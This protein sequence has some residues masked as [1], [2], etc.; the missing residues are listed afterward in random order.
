M[1]IS[2]KGAMLLMALCAFLW[3]TGGLLIKLLPWHPAV[4]SGLRSAIAAL[5][6]LIY[7]KASR[8]RLSFSWKGLGAGV[9]LGAT[10]LLFVWANK[11]TTSANAIVLQ[12]TNPVH[13]VLLSA[14]FLG[15][16]YSRRE[17]LAVAAA[18][19]GVAL[20]FFDQLTPGGLLGNF[21]ALGSGLTMGAMFLFSSRLPDDQQAITS[22][23][24]GHGLAAA[25][26]LLFLPG[27]PVELTPVTVGAIL[28]LGVFQLGVPYIL[29]ALAV[30]RCSPLS[31]S[32]LSMLEPLLNPV[33]VFL[34]MGEKPGFFALAGGIIALTGLLYL[35]LKSPGAH[36][37]G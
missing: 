30:R 2:K 7:M 14:L 26:G 4:I 25:V 37:D 8:M 22:L 5:V 34:A 20:C 29:Y 23:A 21:I 9:C 11:L 12:S 32:L 1:E 6:I 16:R 24:L 31:C 35:Y 15:C 27:S 36:P 17:L 13:I 19:G 3:S 33:W 10:M 28:A 18:M